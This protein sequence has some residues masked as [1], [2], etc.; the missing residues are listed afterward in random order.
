MSIKHNIARFILGGMAKRIVRK[1]QPWVIGITGS[2]GKTMTKE[3][4][5]LVLG[6]SFRVRKNER[7]FNTEIGVP[8]AIIGITDQPLS[9]IDWCGAAGRALWLILRRDPA[10]PTVLVLEMG[11]DHP[12]DIAELISIVPCDI[13]VITAVGPTHLEYF[14]TVEAV[15]KEKSRLVNN[16]RPNGTAILNRDDDLVYPLR[17]KTKASV[18]TFGFAPD[19][20]VRAQDFHMNIDPWVGDS[21]TKVMG[22]SVFKINYHGST[23]PVGFTGVIGTPAVYAAL[24]ATAVGVTMGLHLHTIAERLSRLKSAPGRLSL[25]R[26]IKHALIIDDSYN[27][28]PAAAVEALSVLGT[29]ASSGRRAWAVMGDMW[30]LG[31]YTAQAHRE[32]GAAVVAKA[33]AQYLVTVGERARDSAR[34]AVSA[35]MRQEDVYSFAYTEEAGRFIQ[36]K[37]KEG[38]ILLVKGSRGMHMERIVKELMAEPLRA[39]ELLVHS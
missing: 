27:S 30:E 15:L 28:S 13:G 11:A 1:Y 21:Y 12:G 17:Q 24:A 34:S 25:I 5:A 7:N 39:N 19:A 32:V 29:I 18:V 9:M 37:L 31:A 6:D 8:L 20:M 23:V 38:D 26:G 33:H 10:Y 36:N 16:L 14:Q 22:G 3:A 2:V 4:I 35:G